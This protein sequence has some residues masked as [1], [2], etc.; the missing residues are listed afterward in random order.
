MSSFEQNEVRQ[1]DGIQLDKVFTDKASGKD[2]NRPALE[3]ML[4]YVRDGDLVMVHSMDRLARNLDDLRKMVFDLNARQVKVQF[5]K[6]GLIF[7][8]EDSPMATFQL[9]I[10]GAF[11]E[12][13]RRII[14]ERQMEGI[15]LA[16]KRGVYKGGRKILSDTQVDDLKKRVAA[17]K[18]T[19]THIA[20][21]MNISRE[22]MY[23]YL[24]E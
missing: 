18:E 3:E 8:G 16:K 6:E 19:K 23:K 13:E 20:K 21:D 2:T 10:M 15:A 5:L 14:K 9:S 11:A 4:N 1:L 17:Q 7:T 24:K 22:T 12:F